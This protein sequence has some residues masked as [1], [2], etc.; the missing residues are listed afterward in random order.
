[1]LTRPRL[2]DI[3]AVLQR[4]R[5]MFPWPRGAKAPYQHFRTVTID[6]TKVPNTDQTDFPLLFSGTYPFLA[7]EANGGRCLNAN[8]FDHIFTADLAGLIKLDH[9]IET[10]DPVTGTVNVWVRVP[11]LFTAVDTTIFLRYRNGSI[12]SSQENK[13]AIWGLF[14]AHFKDGTT[15]NTSDSSATNH[16]NNGPGNLSAITG[17]IDGGVRVNNGVTND[18]LN[19]PEISDSLSPTAAVTLSM[20]FKRQGGLG[21]TQIIVNKGDGVN[22]SNSSYEFAFNTSN[23]LRFEVNNGSGWKTAQYSTAITDTTTWHHAMGTFDGSNVR[24]YVDGLLRATTA[25]TGTINNSTA[26][27][28]FGAA[29]NGLFRANAHLDEVRVWGDAKSPDWYTVEWN[30]QSSPATFYAVGPEN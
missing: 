21:N 5:R 26:Q 2:R 27:L 18:V 8:G 28:F 29:S 14:A 20:W 25:F 24:L 15:I 22:N 19:Y 4:Q 23:Q 11:R 12:V 7:T 17:Q 16:T 13:T 30:S 3:D 9:E 10:Y 6:R 1:M